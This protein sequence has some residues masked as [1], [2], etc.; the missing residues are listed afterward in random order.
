MN[1]EDKES[2]EARNELICY[3]KFQR[4][5]KKVVKKME[6]RT[7]EGENL[8]LTKKGKSKDK[9]H[10]CNRLERNKRKGMEQRKQRQTEEER[11]DSKR[12]R[13]RSVSQLGT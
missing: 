12:G 6:R 10:A 1:K 13:K 2:K 11:G 3:R 4:D 5:G 7:A 9:K 8:M